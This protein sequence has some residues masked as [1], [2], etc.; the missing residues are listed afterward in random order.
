MIG[1][2]R[3]HLVVSVPVDQNLPDP[4]G[5]MGFW[6]RALASTH[7]G[8]VSRT[9]P[10]RFCKPEIVYDQA[11]AGR[12]E[13]LAPGMQEECLGGLSSPPPSPTPQGNEYRPQA[14]QG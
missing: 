5:A 3:G 11:E 6:S 1:G 10:T 8:R 13:G 2:P 7:D 12:K 9:Q 14:Y 4:V